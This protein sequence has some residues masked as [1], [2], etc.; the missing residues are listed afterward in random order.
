MCDGPLL[1]VRRQL[2][3]PLLRNGARIVREP[4]HSC[5]EF[6]DCELHSCQKTERFPTRLHDQHD[7]YGPEQAH[8]H[9]SRAVA[10]YRDGSLGHLAESERVPGRACH[11]SPRSTRTVRQ[12]WE[13]ESGSRGPHCLPPRCSRAISSLTDARTRSRKRHNG[14]RCPIPLASM[15]RV[16][17]RHARHAPAIFPYGRVSPDNEKQRK[18]T[19]G[20]VA[21]R[22][23]KK[24]ASSSGSK[25]VDL[26][27]WR[28]S[29]KMAFEAGFGDDGLAL[30][31]LAG[32]DPAT[33]YTLWGRTS[34]PSWPKSV[35]GMREAKG[36]VRIAGAAE[37]EYMPA[38]PPM[39][40]LQDLPGRGLF[41]AR[42]PN[43]I[44]AR[45]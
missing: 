30:G 16:H 12:G 26:A 21:D 35:Y 10:T 6:V 19:I 29:R 23:A 2:C 17:D 14:A 38:G 1:P 41:C 39:S 31:K 9:P 34:P 22:I 42:K 43:E 20:S 27:G 5:V 32:L 8:P 36:Y 13:I 25:V 11:G 28:E 44:E 15:N 37:D 3:L 45:R 7:R 40:P 4:A 24:I 18:H 33:S